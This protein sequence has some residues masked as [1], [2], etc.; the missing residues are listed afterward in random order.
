MLAHLEN[1]EN[2]I[3]QLCVGKRGKLVQ[4]FDRQRD[5]I[6]N[7]IKVIKVN[8]FS[9][10]SNNSQESQDIIAKQ[11]SVIKQH[12]DT[13]Q[14]LTSELNLEKEF[15]EK[16][17]NVGKD[18]SD[19]LITSIAFIKSIKQHTGIKNPNIYGSLC[20]QLLE[21]PFSLAEKMKTPG[22]GNSIHHDVDM[23]LFDQDDYYD[24]TPYI[25]HIKEYF[26]ILINKCHQKREIQ[27]GE[28]KI[29]GVHE[30]TVKKVT[31]LEGI[32]KKNLLNIPHYIIQLQKDDNIIELD[33]STRHPADT[34]WKYDFDVNTIFLTEKG[35]N[36]H[37]DMYDI[38][39]NIKIKQTRCLIDLMMYDRNAFEGYGML[40][41]ERIPHLLQLGFFFT[42][43]LK[44]IKYGYTNITS[45]Y[46]VPE[47][48]METTEPCDITS[49]A[50]PYI[51][52]K[53]ACRCKNRWLS[54]M[55]YLGILTRTGTKYTESILCPYCDE[56]LRVKFVE[57]K[58]KEDKICKLEP[59]KLI[60]QSIPK[61]E[62]T[63][64][65]GEEAITFMRD[66]FGDARSIQEDIP[67]VMRSAFPA[68]NI[69][70]AVALSNLLN[71]LPQR[72]GSNIRAFI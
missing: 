23:V 67:L 39:N 20:R 57:K 2:K 64:Y 56:N 44:I 51:A 54:I 65:F 13:I 61:T 47:F 5:D 63:I 8:Y 40:K 66:L 9:L 30:T 68:I 24:D 46:E 42:H 71:A 69:D 7:I 32:I 15:T 28:Y 70:D 43:R 1:L 25:R 17:V 34:T 37:E 26:D 21:L 3:S 6:M 16:V 36:A 50:A 72:R 31:K 33:I 59:E 10:T 53:I 52:I 48:K 41:Q 27:F 4:E 22:F 29:I 19:K 55:A 38:I 49:M 60:Y 35:F 14:K 58:P 18:F 12:E 45:T 62:G 11:A